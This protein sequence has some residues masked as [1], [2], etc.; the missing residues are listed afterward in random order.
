MAFEASRNHKEIESPP[1]IWAFHPTVFCGAN[2]RQHLKDL[3]VCE[4]VEMKTL[5][6]FFVGQTGNEWLASYPVNSTF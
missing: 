1:L 4:V 5:R 6:C 2:A 3:G